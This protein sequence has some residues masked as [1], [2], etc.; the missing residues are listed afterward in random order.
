MFRPLMYPVLDNN[1]FIPCQDSSWDKGSL[2]VNPLLIMTPGTQ[3]P[4]SPYARLCQ[5][6]HLLG[7]VCLHANEH[8]EPTDTEMHLAEMR[9]LQNATLALLNVQRQDIL[10][11]EGDRSC[12][13]LGAFAL[14]CSALLALYFLHCCIDD[15]H[16]ARADQ[17]NRS[18]GGQLRG[19]VQELAIAGFGSVSMYVLELA[20]L[21][22]D[23][24][25]IL[26]WG[27]K[28]DGPPCRAGTL[29]WP[30]PNIHMDAVYS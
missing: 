20:D 2:A 21:I 25:P 17:H 5:A 19:Q 10:Y 16:L 6:A 8:F 13:L 3:I 12:E 9:P 1:E 22:D 4:T 23:W 15:D 7:K 27:H 29:Q 14:C 24:S 18:R 28:H 26:F 30:L 11:G